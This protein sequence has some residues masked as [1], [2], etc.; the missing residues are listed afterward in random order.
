MA[1]NQKERQHWPLEGTVSVC[2]RR[3]QSKWSLSPRQESSWAEKD[4]LR[5]RSRQMV[6]A[7]QIV[8]WLWGAG[9]GPTTRALGAQVGVAPVPEVIVQPLKLPVSN[10][11]LTQ[12]KAIM[13]KRKKRTVKE[14][15]TLKS[16]GRRELL[17]QTSCGTGRPKENGA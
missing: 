4:P 1:A 14:S 6:G 10:P 15:F 8:P 9:P 16:F 7:T 2:S 13:G 17:I 5:T 11:G 3:T 12:G